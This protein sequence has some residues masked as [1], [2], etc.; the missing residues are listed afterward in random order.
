MYIRMLCHPL[1]VCQ[2]EPCSPDFASD[3]GDIDNDNCSSSEC[4]ETI[5]ATDHDDQVS[6]V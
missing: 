1:F 5:L 2:K 4:E 6:I 3:G